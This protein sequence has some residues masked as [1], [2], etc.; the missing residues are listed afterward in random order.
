MDSPRWSPDGS[1]LL[2]VERTS[3]GTKGS[4]FLV[5]RLGGVVRP[6]A[7]AEFACWF[8][9]KGTQIVTANLS[10]PSG[11]RGVRLMNRLTGEVKEIRLPDYEWLLDVDCSART[12]AILAAA[13]KSD[14]YQIWAFKADGGAPRK[15]VEGDG[16]FS[17]RWSPSGD[18]IY[19]MRAKG[20]TSEM[21]KLSV[22]GRDQPKVLA[23]GLQTGGSFTLAADGSRLAYTRKADNSNLWRISLPTSEKSKAVATRLTSGTSY[24]GAPS[25]SPDGHWITFTFGANGEASNVFKM[26]ATDGKPVQLTFFEHATTS[27]PVFSP[28]GRRIA[29]ISD[30]SG[31]PK[32][33]TIP[34]DGGLA[35]IL[36]NTN[37]ADPHS[38]PSWWPAA[39]ILYQQPG[40]RNLMQINGKTHEQRAILKNEK[41]LGV[42]P[43]RPVP[44]PDG[45]KI[46]L[47]SIQDDA[48]GLWII[49]LEPYSEISL[50]TDVWPLGWSPDGRYVYAMRGV[51]AHEVLRVQVNSPHEVVSVAALPDEVAETDGASV[52]A[53]GKEVVVT[54]SEEVSDVWLMENIDPSW[55]ATRNP[56]Q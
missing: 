26:S 28:D 9:P 2:F 31:A 17:P 12:G 45:K 50:K 40:F 6:L 35:Q 54:I 43:N 25:F 8:D 53:D 37:A 52:S 55:P 13:V 39:E 51:E 44:S 48:A 42:I 46:A 18:A 3:N 4:V 27:G 38:R 24:H 47:Y 16:I 56:I 34:A 1:E 49:S 5:S 29:F 15:L 30:Q 22:G 19:F 36:E 41:S 11:F 21:V 33:W 14:K 32:V 7:D 10:G 20:S 23:S